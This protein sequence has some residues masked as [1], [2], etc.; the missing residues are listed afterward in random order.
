MWNPFT[1]PLAQ[2]A[3]ANGQVASLPD[4]VDT[5][6]HYNFPTPPFEWSA[7]YP[8]FAGESP[9]GF[10]APGGYLDDVMQD[11]HPDA[12]PD[13]LGHSGV[14]RYDNRGIAPDNSA[15]S[16][17]ASDGT[18]DMLTPR[19]IGGYAGTNNTLRMAGPVGGGDNVYSGYIAKM[20]SPRPGVNGPV[21]GGSDYANQLAISQYASQAVLLSQEAAISALVSAV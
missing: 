20:P 12:F 3:G 2:G 9:D 16:I 1:T 15:S 4:V 11:R 21:S 7:W 8:E 5:G 14:T 17:I 10:Y 6:E 18:P 13:Y 19:D